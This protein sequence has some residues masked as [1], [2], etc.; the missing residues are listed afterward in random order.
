MRVLTRIGGVERAPH[1]ILVV[2]VGP[3]AVGPPINLST[4]DDLPK[5]AKPPAATRSVAA[6][7]VEIARLAVFLAGAGPSYL[8]ATRHF[9]R[10]R[11]DA[12]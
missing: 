10:R 7:P 11:S 9:R 5:L 12:K 4:M 6:Q 8:T 3:G 1:G 2:G